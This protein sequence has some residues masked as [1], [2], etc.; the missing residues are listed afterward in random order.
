[1]MKFIFK[2]QIFGLMLFSLI[3]SCGGDMSEI[4]P[5][6]SSSHHGSGDISFSIF[7]YSGGKKRDFF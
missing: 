5:D 6:S 2:F 4:V 1:M 7:N 3:V